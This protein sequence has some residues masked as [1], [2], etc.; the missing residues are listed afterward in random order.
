M[1]FLKVYQEHTILVCENIFKLIQN[2]PSSVREDQTFLIEGILSALLHDIGKAHAGFQ[3][4]LLSSA[5]IK[6]LLVSI[7]VLNYV[8]S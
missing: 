2:S 3:D 4:L 8:T 7:G 6:K 5:G 1:V